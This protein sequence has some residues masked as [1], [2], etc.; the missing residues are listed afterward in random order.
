MRETGSL[1]SVAAKLAAERGFAE[2]VGSIERGLRR[3]RDRGQRDG[4]VWGRRLLRAF[5]LPAEVDDRVRWM[6]QYHTRFTDLPTPLC[7][8]LLL[9]WD[10]PPVSE[11]PARVWIQLG[12]ASVALRQRRAEIAAAHLNQAATVGAAMPRAAAVE[13]HLVRAFLLA[14]ADPSQ[15]AE[16]LARA[17]TALT[18]GDLDPDTAACLRA[19]LVDQRAYGLNKPR[20]GPAD[21]AAALA[22]YEAI[23]ADGPVFARCRRH[24]GMGWSLLGLGRR[25]EALEHARHSVREAGDAG[26]LRLRAMALNLLAAAASGDAAKSAG[27]RAA[28][29]A[30]GLQDEALA[31]R[32]ARHVPDPDAAN[33]E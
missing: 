1:A 13:L 3:L 28:S 12:L 11:S 2:G 17:D 22:A 8:E 7:R 33:D 32:Y 5:G 23:P 30:Q 24:N 26:S 29:I 19:R 6:G 27:R 15:A 20:T 10:R 16:C 9:P 18:T 4:G 14:R 21:P 31:A 25:D